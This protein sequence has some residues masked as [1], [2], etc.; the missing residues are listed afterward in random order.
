M[1]WDGRGLLELNED[2]R[3]SRRGRVYN[4]GGLVASRPRATASARLAA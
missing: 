1:A 3:G 2:H 4:G